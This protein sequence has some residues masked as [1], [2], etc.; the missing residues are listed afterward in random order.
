MCIAKATHRYSIGVAAILAAIT[1]ALSACA[2]TP[3]VVEVP[4]E[5]QVVEKIEV[6][7]EVENIVTP[8]PGPVEEFADASA[9]QNFTTTW[10]RKWPAP[11]PLYAGGEHQTWTHV[12]Y[13]PCFNLDEDLGLMP[14]YCQSFEGNENHTSY[15]VTLVEDA[16]WSD[17]TPITAQ[18]VADW[19]NYITKPTAD[20]PTRDC[21]M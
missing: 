17:G 20:P 5:V 10:A 6:V 14:G 4:R 11:S 13:Q 21:K 7:K 19:Y 8:T 9:V 15:T 12:L 3:Q 18:Q 2:T 16:V 1:M